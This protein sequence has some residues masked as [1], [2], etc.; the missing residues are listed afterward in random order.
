MLDLVT[1]VII[2]NNI[3]R[4]YCNALQHMYKT[5]FILNLLTF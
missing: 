3:D 5:L 4:T 2:H 1:S